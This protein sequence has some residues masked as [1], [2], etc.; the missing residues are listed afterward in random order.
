M[1]GQEIAADD[2]LVV[3]ESPKVPSALEA[4]AR[5]WQEAATRDGPDG[6]QGE[7]GKPPIDPGDQLFLDLYTKHRLLSKHEYAKIRDVYAPRFEADQAGVIEQVFGIPRATC[8]G[9]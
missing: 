2:A 1:P 3:G 7:A 4:A 9:G 6:G 5:K 8:G